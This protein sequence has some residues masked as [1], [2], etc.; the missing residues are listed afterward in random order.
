[1]TRVGVRRAAELMFVTTVEHA[2][3]SR[4]FA[5]REDRASARTP[6]TVAST[7]RQYA[8]VTLVSCAD[9]PLVIFISGP[10][11]ESVAVRLTII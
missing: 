4:F 7:R 9:N 8:S 6:K 3:R 2:Q 1:M 10:N 5:C 11:P